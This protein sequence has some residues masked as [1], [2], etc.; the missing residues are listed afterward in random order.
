MFVR[1]TC[2]CK[3][4]YQVIWWSLWLSSSVVFA[5]ISAHTC[6][7][8]FSTNFSET[9]VVF[10]TVTCLP[11]LELWKHEF[12]CCALSSWKVNCPNWVFLA[13]LDGFLVCQKLLGTFLGRL[14]WI[15]AFIFLDDFVISLSQITDAFCL[16]FPLSHACEYQ[17]PNKVK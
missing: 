17:L 15:S 3:G 7:L 11:F 10:Q 6:G 13:K 9:T 8:F 1:K 2:D 14:K 5:E 16:F 12:R 4:N